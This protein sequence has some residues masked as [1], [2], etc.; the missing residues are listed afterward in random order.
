MEWTFLIPATVTALA[1]FWA[2]I[3]NSEVAPV[4]VDFGHFQVAGKALIALVVS[5][6]AFLIWA[7][8]P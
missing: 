3:E 1:F 8:V 4:W 2:G 6:A 5:L 7:L